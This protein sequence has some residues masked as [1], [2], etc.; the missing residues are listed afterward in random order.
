M[1]AGQRISDVAI[2]AQQR[3][4]SVAS[5]YHGDVVL[6]VE[7][8]FSRSD[9]EFPALPV[10]VVTLLYHVSKRCAEQH[11]SLCLVQRQ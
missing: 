6:R 5:V 4:G 11:Q 1:K 10:Y 3:R 8:V 7:Q 9:T 2:Q